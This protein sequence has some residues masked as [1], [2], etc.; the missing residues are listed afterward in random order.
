M[1][2]FSKYALTSIAALT[3]ASPFV[4][5]DGHAKDKSVKQDIDAKVT[6][7]T[8]APKALKALPGSENVKNHYKDYVVTDVKKDNK[9]FTHYT[10][11][12]KVGNVFA[13]DEEVKVHV[14]TE[15]KVVLINGDT[16]AKKVKPTNEVSINKEQAS[17]KAF[18]AVNLNPK[19]AKNMKDDAVKTNKVQ[20]DGK[21]NK[22]VY[23]V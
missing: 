6:Q 8:D 22:Y 14:N 18:E 19:K 2:N 13:P 5:M 10:L 20:I 9:G 21:T 7:Q 1:K 16:D 15:G 3:V 23:N 4:T 11:Q 17:K 12:P